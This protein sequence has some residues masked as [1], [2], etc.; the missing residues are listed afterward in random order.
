MNS[1]K[2]N[3]NILHDSALKRIFMVIIIDQIITTK[4][5][6]IP[7]VAKRER[8]EGH[9]KARNSHL[10]II[11]KKQTMSKTDHSRNSTIILFAN[12]RAIT[13]EMVKECRNSKRVIASGEQDGGRGQREPGYCWVLLEA[14]QHCIMLNHMHVL[15]YNK[16]HF[17]I[18]I[19]ALPT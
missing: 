15:L 18:K 16:N 7:L 11:Q 10:C 6:I 13:E 2:Y 14:F 5:A 3:L 1:W 19:A 8:K 17:K 12:M 9:R 4:C